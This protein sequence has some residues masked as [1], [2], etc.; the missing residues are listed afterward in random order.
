[1]TADERISSLVAGLLDEFVRL[2]LA[3]QAPDPADFVRRAGGEGTRMQELI[4]LF[5]AETEP[6]LPAP[7]TA[8]D[9]AERF[10]P[11]AEPLSGGEDEAAESSPALRELIAL[12]ASAA[13]EK[14]EALLDHLA[15]PISVLRLE[16]SSHRGV[17]TGE[18]AGATTIQLNHPQ[19]GRAEL[20]DGT[21]RLVLYGIPPEFLGTHP[22]VAFPKAQLPGVADLEWA[23]K[24]EGLPPGV[25][26]ADAPVGERREM[27]AT[28]GTVNPSGR[29]LESLL[30]GMRVIFTGGETVDEQG[31]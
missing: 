8:R 18:S 4:A 1:V 12:W 3:G 27:R 14:R 16:P 13:T 25:V 22:L 21:L 7:A 19:G 15:A 20:E 29:S 17:P 6:V 10:G 2:H 28:V 31:S 30:E 5:L 9:L 24:S 23:G 26:R 11:K